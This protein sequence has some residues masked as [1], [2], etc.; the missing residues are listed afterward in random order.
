MT[1]FWQIPKTALL[2]A[3]QLPQNLLGLVLFWWYRRDTAYGE[4][5]FR[6]VRVLYSERMRGGL[7]LGGYVIVPF[8]LFHNALAA[9]SIDTIAHEWGHT[10]QSLLLGW[11][12]LPLVGFQSLAHVALHR[13]VCGKA[14][15][16]H[17]WT[18]R[19]ADRLG[20]VNRSS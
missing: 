4:G 6:G 9:E 2:W 10:R 17:F 11:L 14:D 12:Y 1:T 7:S 19:W 5:M 13:G 20:G 15:Y 8:G 18:E 3:W 16:H